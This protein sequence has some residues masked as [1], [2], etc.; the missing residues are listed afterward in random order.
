MPRSRLFALLTIV[1]AMALGVAI[2]EV[3]MRVRHPGRTRAAIIDRV[4]RERYTWRRP[5]ATFHHVGDGLYALRFPSGN[6]P[7]RGRIAIIGDS[8]TM[9][10]GVDPERRFG[11][12]LQ[13]D[14]SRGDE[15]TVLAAS[16]Y[17]PSIYRNIVRRA[18]STARYDA[19]AVFVDQTDPPDDLIYQRDRLSP[20][21]DHQFDVALMIERQAEVDGAW[22]EVS[23]SLSGWTGLARRS[24][25]VNLLIPP[26]TILDT[27]PPDS[28]HLEYLRMSLSRDKLIHA[29]ETAPDK[30]IS[31][32]MERQLF[33]HLDEIVEHC[34]ERGTP[35]ILAAVPWEYHVAAQP[36]Y[37]GGH[38]GPFPLE[39][40]LETIL[41][42]HYRGAPG[43]SVIPLTD[44]FRRQ[45]DPSALFLDRP[46]NEFH[47]NEA[48][49][50]VAARALREQLRAS[51]LSASPSREER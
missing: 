3:T 15:V 51:G 39:N 26:P 48:G 49:H 46:L 5:D 32:M 25:L 42:Q 21:D 16:S 11:S 45:A 4:G 7:D 9:G 24:V 30:P 31:R 20:G 33:S 23:R 50:A 14:M 22:D 18:L 34:R 29:F 12:L 10:Y 27:F 8:F 37:T 36:R 38:S 1:L 13:R 47:W 43:V 28:R 2:I 17:A 41:A 44:A 19:V 35:V 40:R 6:E